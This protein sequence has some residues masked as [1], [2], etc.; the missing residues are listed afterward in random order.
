MQNGRSVA[1]FARWANESGVEER[2]R[3]KLS[4]GA[5][6]ASAD[7]CAFQRIC[8]GNNADDAGAD[9]CIN[10][11]RG[12]GTNLGGGSWEAG[13]PR[14]FC[15][16]SSAEGKQLADDKCER[17]PVMEENRD[18][19]LRW[20]LILCARNRC[21]DSLE[22]IQTLEQNRIFFFCFFLVPFTNKKLC[23]W[24]L[25]GYWQHSQPGVCS[26][27]KHA[28]EK[29]SIFAGSWK[30]RHEVLFPGNQELL[31]LFFF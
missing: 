11:P 18:V 30:Q 16:H 9:S 7:V 28:G 27:L 26:P 15:F 4:E 3:M 8:L 6:A 10:E 17:F 29:K 12:P 24:L 25:L 1:R 14:T 19:G 22:Q 2:S 31:F 20:G 13:A 21:K 5:W 23:P